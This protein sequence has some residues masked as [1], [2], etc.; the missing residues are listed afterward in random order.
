MDR[1]AP[2]TIESDEQ[3]IASGRSFKRK[4]VTGANGST[5]MEHWFV[6]GLG[7]AW[8]GGQTG[9]SY[10]DSKGPDASAEM[11]RFFFDTDDT[12]P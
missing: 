11:I 4:I 12:Q 10:T 1:G 6:D 5:E 8:S 9:G 2:L 3:G 7:H